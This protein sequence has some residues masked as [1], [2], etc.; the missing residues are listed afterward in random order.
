LQETEE[1]LLNV[2]EN[3]DFETQFSDIETSEQKKS[4]V[5]LD[6]LN[7]VSGREDTKFKPEE[8]IT[9]KEVIKI[10]TLVSGTSVAPRRSS[11]VADIDASDWSVPYVESALESEIL[12]LDKSN[13]LGGDLPVTAGEAFAIYLLSANV[14]IDVDESDFVG[15]SRF[16]TVFS[17]DVIVK[18]YDTNFVESD[19]LTRADFAK[20]STDVLMALSSLSDYVPTEQLVGE[21]Y[22]ASQSSKEESNIL[23]DELLEVLLK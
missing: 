1:K 14:C 10:S 7:I 2:V 5:L 8:K 3:S 17:P 20:I 21:Q 15:Y 6:A 19:E 12:S 9:R 18:N 13:T 16:K 23:L 4:I 11:S 22:S